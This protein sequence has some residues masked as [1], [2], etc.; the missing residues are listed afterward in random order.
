LR[1]VHLCYYN[2]V[3]VMLALS[4][5]A[6]L[7]ATAFAELR[8]AVQA[9]AADDV[10][11]AGD[12]ALAEDLVALRRS[13]DLLEYE[14]SR[15]LLRFDRSRG[16]AS[17]GATSAVSWLRVRCRL[18]GVVAAQRVE[19]AR[20][21]PDLPLTEAALRE[22]EI[23]FQHAAVIAR[24]AEEL[25]SAA[26][27]NV[28]PTL[29]E[30]AQKLDPGRLRL[31]TQHLRHCVDPDGTL[32]AAN[33][34]H[35]RRWL[36][37]SPTLDGMVVLNGHLDAEGGALVRAAVNALATPTPG[38]ARTSAQRRAD[39]LVELATRQLHVGE[40]PLTAGQRPHL[41]I[42]AG[43]DTLRR[44]PGAAAGDIGWGGTVP[45]ETVRRLA[46]DAALTRVTLDD[47]GSP[48]DV[49]KTART[50]SAVQRRALVVR[51]RG[52]RFP[53]CDRPPEWTD[54]HHLRHWADGGETTLD[55]LVLL[56]RPHHRMVHEE[57]WRLERTP[58]GG[59]LNAVP[60]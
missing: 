43:A 33:V 42:T 46:C 24:S 8:V 55:N 34:D 60:P 4:P 17:D 57:G 32:G 23:G 30:A 31:V 11:S 6:G 16:Y 21:L 58:E 3:V 51:D 41:T 9:I 15:R 39:A 2:I 52:C 27:R 47:D 50:V 35:G 5:A 18:S 20:K 45:A 28:E 14:F 7:P 49:G 29:V 56:C 44:K 54:A 22:G 19:V 37:L 48:I 53:G 40:L 12:A 38:D 25:G 36:H 26:V 10:E 1:R 59:G 13:I